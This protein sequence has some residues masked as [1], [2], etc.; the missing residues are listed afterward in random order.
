MG[1]VGA[2]W[3]R[4]HASARPGFEG[5]RQKLLVVLLAE[6]AVV[7]AGA[8]GMSP[9]TEK[10][11]WDNY[12]RVRKAVMKAWPAAPGSPPRWYFDTTREKV[13]AA[14]GPPGDY[15]TGPTANVAQY[16]PAAVQGCTTFKWQ[17]DRITIY[18]QMTKGGEV[19]DM[20]ATPA[21][22]VDNNPVESVLWRAKRQ[23]HRWFPE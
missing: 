3:L 12:D 21:F 9:R 11:S 18:I 5:W 7:L 20:Q 19:F 13:E 4:F 16:A 15:R 2:L 14:L 22:P 10:V 8:V 6:L 1:L 17:G 23:W